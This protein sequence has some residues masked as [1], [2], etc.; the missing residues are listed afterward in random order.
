MHFG[1][2][3]LLL[4]KDGFAEET[5]WSWSGVPI[6]DDKSDT[7]Q[8]VFVP[9][10]DNTDNVLAARRLG[11]IRKVTAACNI[12]AS[13]TSMFGSVCAAIDE[14]SEDIPFLAVYDCSA[15]TDER[16]SVVDERQGAMD[17][18]SSQGPSSPRDSSNKVSG[19][20][21]KAEARKLDRIS[22]GSDVVYLRAAVAGVRAGSAL[23][24]ESIPAAQEGEDAETLK[25]KVAF[26]KAFRKVQTTHT[27]LV[28]YKDDIS[29]FAEELDKTKHG[30][31]VNCI[32][33]LP[34][35]T[36][37]GTLRAVAIA[38]LN[39][40]RPWDGDY[41]DFIELFRATLSSGIANIRLVKE[42]LRRHRITAAIVRSKNEE[43]QA[44]LASRTRELRISEFRYSRMAE[45]LPIGLS[46]A[47]PESVHVSWNMPVSS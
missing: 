28:L 11:V 8:G 24:P 36:A 42:E 33:F 5:Y 13:A 41:Q 12:A 27:M 20:A 30:D 25:T 7:V 14:N 34:I 17:Q 31:T 26:L 32:A 3:Q 37:D 29:T 16:E 22:N 40:R 38:A 10:F 44:L 9:A 19:N 2:T 45:L 47:G 15:A 39:P 4:Y 46:L 18:D 23:F 43:L 1:N 21:A 6:F 35:L